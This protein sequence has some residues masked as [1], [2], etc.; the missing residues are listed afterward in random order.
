M[1]KSPLRV[2][3]RDLRILHR[4]ISKWMRSK[5][6]AIQKMS[7]LKRVLEKAKQAEAYLMPVTA[8]V[9]TEL[10]DGHYWEKHP[11][12]SYIYEMRELF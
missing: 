2:V 11:Q 8:E 6:I 9:L 7:H 12:L 3:A 1:R 4:E 10:N 5:E